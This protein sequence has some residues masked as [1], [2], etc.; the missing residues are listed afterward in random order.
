MAVVA[1]PV[2]HARG[3]GKLY[4]IGS[5]AAVNRTLREAVTAGVGRALGVFRREEKSHERRNPAEIWALRNVDLTVDSGEVVG[6]IGPNGAGKSTLLKILARITTPTT[7]RVELRGRVRSLLEVG[8]GFHPE[9]SGR[10]N[11]Y[12]NGAILGMRRIEIDERFDEIVAF[13]EVERFLDTPVKRYSSGMYVRL[14]FAVAAHLE[15]EVLLVDEVLA[16]GDLAFQRKCVGKMGEV[17]GKGRTVLFVS[18]QLA[19]ISTLCERAILLQEGRVTADGPAAGVLKTYQDRA[20]PGF[21]EVAR[22]TFSDDPSR[23]GSLVAVGIQ[24]AGGRGCSRFEVLEPVT[25][26]V[27]YDVRQP[28]TG[29]ALNLALIRQGEMILLSFDTDQ[30]QTLLEVREPGRYEAR[31]VVPGLL[32]AGGYSLTF[33]LGR[34]NGSSIH[35]ERDALRFE[36]TE[37]SIDTSMCSFASR[38][39]GSVAVPLPWTTRRVEGARDLT[40]GPVESA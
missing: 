34:P 29:V 9:L 6:V 26:V 11:I 33:S 37:L 39:A 4:R 19:M 17:A 40:D 18:H 25:V 2:I 10:E 5:R 13:A 20:G 31:A 16:V 12:L 36:V 24:D 15:P 30:D 28:L 32:K 1:F 8:T 14:A 21:G 3:L 27:T 7:G 35:V 38:R 22:A 23:P